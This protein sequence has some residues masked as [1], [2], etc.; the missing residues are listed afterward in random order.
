MQDKAGLS[1]RSLAVG[2][3]TEG[4]SGAVAPPRG[5]VLFVGNSL[6]Y[7]NDLPALTQAIF[8]ATDD[9]REVAS[10]TRPNF[11]LED[12]WRERSAQRR[13]L[14]GE[15]E[16][17]VLQ[18][19]PS[20]RQEGGENLA[21]YARRFGEL[22]ESAGARPAL[23]SVWTPRADDAYFDRAIASYENAAREA[24]AVLCPAAAAWRAA[25]RVSP[26][27]RLYSSDDFHP[28]VLG[29]YLA[30]LAIHAALTGRAPFEAEVLR[31]RDGGGFRVPADL[32]LVLSTAVAEAL[33]DSRAPT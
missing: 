25:W 30:A 9:P 15:W 22:I 17:V 16:W 3:A 6:T 14:R 1:R 4:F 19:G 12:H 27:L 31:T 18:Q 5:G 26:D 13:I 10:V 2:M 21:T 7:S 20:S 33:V 32:A 8:D 23:Y 29:S 24:S 11:S 28:S